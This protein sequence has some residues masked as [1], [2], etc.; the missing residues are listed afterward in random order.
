MPNALPIQVNLVPSN[1]YGC[2]KKTRG[3]CI[4]QNTFAYRPAQSTLHFRA[5][6]HA[7]YI[8]RLPEKRLQHRNLR[9]QT[10]RRLCGGWVQHAIKIQKNQHDYNQFKF[11]LKLY[12]FMIFLVLNFQRLRVK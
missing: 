4:H 12:Q 1:P 5:Q 11:L 9:P 6:N 2:R 10:V 7:I 8:F 3:R